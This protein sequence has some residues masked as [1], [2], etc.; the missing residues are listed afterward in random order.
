VEKNPGSRS[1]NRTASQ[2]GGKKRPNADGKKRPVRASFVLARLEKK[3]LKRR[4]GKPRVHSTPPKRARNQSRRDWIG[5]ADHRRSRSA[6]PS[7]SSGVGA[8]ERRDHASQLSNLKPHPKP[9]RANTS[10]TTA[11][12]SEKNKTGTRGAIDRGLLRCLPERWTAG[13]RARKN[14]ST[15]VRGRRG[16]AR[17][18]MRAEPGSSETRSLGLVYMD[19]DRVLRILQ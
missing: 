7:R 4:K 12:A 15:A 17:L 11:R 18:V 1:E 2:D 10:T 16:E 9:P 13:R 6:E 14:G 8:P 19:L 5:T 3:T